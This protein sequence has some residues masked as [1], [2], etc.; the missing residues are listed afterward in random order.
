MQKSLRPKDEWERKPKEWPYNPDKLPPW[1]VD[2]GKGIFAKCPK[3]GKI[4]TIRTCYG[5]K[6]LMCEE[7]L[8]EHQITCLRKL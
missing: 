5:C 6:E 3:C 4:T 7:C 8:T 2:T 1:L